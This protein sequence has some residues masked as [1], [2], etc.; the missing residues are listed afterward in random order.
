MLEKHSRGRVRGSEPE[1][2]GRG[3]TLLFT[4]VLVNLS[5]NTRHCR[6]DF[7]PFRTD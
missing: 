1:V 5:L 6:H 7:R 3:L 2:I 4:F